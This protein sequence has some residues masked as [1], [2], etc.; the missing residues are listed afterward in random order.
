MLLLTNLVLYAIIDT[1]SQEFAPNSGSHLTPHQ[2]LVLEGFRLANEM[3]PE[4]PEAVHAYDQAVATMRENIT[5]DF[6]L[7]LS[8][9]QEF[10]G[11]MAGLSVATARM[12]ELIDMG[13]PPETASKVLRTTLAGL[14][15]PEGGTPPFPEQ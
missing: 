2:A 8:D 9:R 12:V 4:A 6:G 5:G 13:L 14:L 7:E 15:P 3:K 1:M 11:V 10:Y